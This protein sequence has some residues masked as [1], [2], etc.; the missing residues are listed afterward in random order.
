MSIKL[1]SVKCPECGASL[2]IE[3]DRKQAFCSYCG[4]KILIH[5]ENEYI[6]HYVDE[7]SVKKAENERKTIEINEKIWQEE[8]NEEQEKHRNGI[9][10]I[11]IGAVLFGIGIIKYS[12]SANSD[13][14]TIWDYIEIVGFFMLIIGWSMTKKKS[15]KTL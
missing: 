5:N 13:A 8:R 2:S 6:F 14:I 7:A 1:I 3:E 15:S 4:A 12:P 10:I 11:I 9:K